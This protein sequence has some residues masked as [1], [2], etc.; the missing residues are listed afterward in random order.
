M[1]LC[2]SLYRSLCVRV[3]LC[4]FVR[5]SFMCLYVCL[6]VCLCVCVCVC[7]CVSLSTN[8]DTLQD[9]T[10]L[11]AAM[12]SCSHVRFCFQVFLGFDFS[13]SFFFFFFSF[14]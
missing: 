11:N 14:F 2:V 1:S 4:P 7:M 9:L 8:L 10:V 5:V 12:F 13:F 3:S 6:Y